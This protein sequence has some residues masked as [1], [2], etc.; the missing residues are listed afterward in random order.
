M[1]A[2][3]KNVPIHEIQGSTRS[4]R[5]VCG[6]R[7]MYTEYGIISLYSEYRHSNLPV[8]KK[9]TNKSEEKV[10]SGI[11]RAKKDGNRSHIKIN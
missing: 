4:T 7:E 3:Y 6:V 1:Y 2:E 8:Q 11:R 9:S 5:N 10:T